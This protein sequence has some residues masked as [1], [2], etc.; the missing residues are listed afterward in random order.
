MGRFKDLVIEAVTSDLMLVVECRKIKYAL[1]IKKYVFTV[2]GDHT[3]QIIHKLKQLY[4]EELEINY[5]LTYKFVEDRL[6][7]LRFTKHCE[8]EKMMNRLRDHGFRLLIPYPQSPASSSSPTI[9]LFHS[10]LD[11]LFE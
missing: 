2:S 9:Q 6:I 11:S 5:H 10:F 8:I 1:N 7:F 3:P 4:I